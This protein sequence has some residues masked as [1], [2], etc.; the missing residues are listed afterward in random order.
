MKYSKEQAILILNLFIAQN[1]SRM[2]SDFTQVW[3][4]HKNIKIRDLQILGTA[5]CNNYISWIEYFTDFGFV[6][7]SRKNWKY[8]KFDIFKYISLEDKI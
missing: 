3:N 6:I 7:Y 1:E 4:L 8:V 5:L 2:L